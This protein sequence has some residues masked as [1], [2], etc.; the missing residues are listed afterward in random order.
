MSVGA[1]IA[2]PYKAGGRSRRGS[3]KAGT[4]VGEMY[5]L[6]RLCII[7]LMPRVSTLMHGKSKQK[8]QENVV[9]L[10]DNFGTIISQGYLKMDICWTS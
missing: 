10:E 3:P 5:M 6:Q 8:D 2:W 4:T 9:P 7:N 1:L